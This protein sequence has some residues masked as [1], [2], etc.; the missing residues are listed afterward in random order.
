MHNE[1]RNFDKNLT[2]PEI[3]VSRVRDESQLYIQKSC[4]GKHVITCLW[5][6]MLQDKRKSYLQISSSDEN[7]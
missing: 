2:Q 3:W 6:F 5:Y 1:V 4:Y 7:L